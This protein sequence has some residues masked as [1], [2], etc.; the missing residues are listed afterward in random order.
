MAGNCV[1]S[2]I[3]VASSPTAG[4]SACTCPQCTPGYG[5]G[6]P[7]I[8]QCDATSPSG[9]TSDLIRDCQDGWRLGLLSHSS[10]ISTNRWSFCPYSYPSFSRTLRG[11]PRHRSMGCHLTLWATQSFESSACCGQAT[12]HGNMQWIVTLYYSNTFHCS[13]YVSTMT[14][15]F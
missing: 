3:P 2:A 11:K 5:G 13:P 15:P 9:D 4:H 8:D 10:S 14:H 12:V 1:S 6:S 7:G